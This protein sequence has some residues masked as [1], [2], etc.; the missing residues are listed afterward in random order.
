[1]AFPIP[2]TD[3]D[4][5][6]C[7]KLSGVKSPVVTCMMQYNHFNHKQT[8]DLR[9]LTQSAVFGCLCP[10]HVKYKGKLETL[11]VHHFETG[12]KLSLLNA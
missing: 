1:M 3:S 11:L 8:H 7:H 12:D 4:T 10:E 6:L 5:S 2:I 9:W